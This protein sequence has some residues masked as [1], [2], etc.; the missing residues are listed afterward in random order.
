[1]TNEPKLDFSIACKEMLKDCMATGMQPPFHM[2]AVAS[3]GACLF[4]RFTRTAQPD[5]LSFEALSHHSADGSI[6][7][8]I[9][10]MMVD[11]KG[12]VSYGTVIH[13]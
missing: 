1:M 12:A 2:A 3:N 9:K 7:A 11:A 5:D 10:V 4:G 13:V 6:Y 8:P